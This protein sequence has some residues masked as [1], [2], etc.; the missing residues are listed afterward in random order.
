MLCNILFLTNTG[1]NI[2]ALKVSPQDLF[3]LLWR[4]LVPDYLL[5]GAWEGLKTLVH[6]VA[7]KILNWNLEE[8]FNEEISWDT[9][10][11]QTLFLVNSIIMVRHL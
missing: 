6:Y 9:C 10:I 3:S 1:S 2:L 7:Y 4:V 8:N 5:A 11:K